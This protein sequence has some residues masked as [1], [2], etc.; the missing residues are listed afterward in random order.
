MA[1]E[2]ISAHPGSSSLDLSYMTTP[3]TV[4]AVSGLDPNPQTDIVAWSQTC[5]VTM[6]LP[7]RPGGNWHVVGAVRNQ[8]PQLHFDMEDGSWEM[9]LMLNLPQEKLSSVR[10]EAPSW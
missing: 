8:Q 2:P 3:A 6:D 4:T 5:P 7:G 1:Q 10:S 9:G